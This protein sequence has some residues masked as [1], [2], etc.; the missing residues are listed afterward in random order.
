MMRECATYNTI[1]LAQA[2]LKAQHSYLD[3]VPGKKDDCRELSASLKFGALIV[4]TLE[5]LGHNMCH[6]AN[7]IHDLMGRKLGSAC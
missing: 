4:W 5:L 7:N 3:R 6:L 1:S 2:G